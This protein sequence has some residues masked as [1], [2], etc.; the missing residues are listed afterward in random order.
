[1]HRG[2]F[3]QVPPDSLNQTISK[4]LEWI[5]WTDKVRRD[6]TVFVKPNFT[7]PV[8]RPGVVTSPKFLS[9]LLPLLKDRAARVLVGESDLPTFRT[10]KA[11][12]GLGIDKICEESGAEMVELTRGASEMVE[13][14]VQGRRIRVRLPRLILKET[15]VLVNAAVPK[16]HVVTGM[17]GAMKNLYGLIPDPFRGNKH[18][19]EIIRAI[20]AVNKIVRSDIVVVDGLYSLAGRGPIM[21]KP[22]PTNVLIAADNAVA[23]DAIVCR[24]FEM[25]PT[26]IG[27]LRL[28]VNEKLGSTAKDAIEMAGPVSSTIRLRPRRTIMDY[29]AV[30]TFKS[31]IVNRA[32]M[33]SPMTPLLYRA[34]RPFRSNKEQEFY[35]QDIGSLPQSQ[36]AR[37]KAN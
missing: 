26:K 24:F 22:I 28:A 8:F 1:M 9:E 35:K 10:S 23:A 36:F 30:L 33:S 2:F 4:A 16:C 20:V 17:S 15:D 12:Q 32:V 6:S 21:G 7:W 5:G 19:H 25:D 29:F 13:T 18:R 14:R 31:R 37:D 27:H 3:S 11:F 34:L